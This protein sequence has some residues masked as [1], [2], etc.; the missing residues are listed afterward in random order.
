MTSMTRTR[1]T[2]AGTE[3]AG[4]RD[5]AALFLTTRVTFGFTLGGP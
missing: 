1:E 3:F 2:G 4:P 5:R